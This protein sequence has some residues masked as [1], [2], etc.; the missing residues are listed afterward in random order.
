MTRNDRD[1]RRAFA[2]SAVALPL[3]FGFAGGVLAIGLGTLPFFG[4]HV[5]VSFPTP[6]WIM[7]GFIASASVM[8]G[9]LPTAKRASSAAMAA[10]QRSS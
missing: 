2:L 4:A 8:L 7:I 6:S 3:L 5:A 10:S 1:D 9:A